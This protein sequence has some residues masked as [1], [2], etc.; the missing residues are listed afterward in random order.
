[1]Y[2]IYV[3]IYIYVNRY[4]GL[5]IGTAKTS[6]L[7]RP[8]QPWVCLEMGY[9]DSDLQFGDFNAEH[10][11]NQMDLPLASGTLTLW[12]ITILTGKSSLNGYKLF[13]FHSYVSH[14]QRVGDGD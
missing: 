5:L 13:I 7:F 11:K 3:Y 6:N 10:D 12:K 2:I 4:R 14:Y 9:T 8:V 1:M